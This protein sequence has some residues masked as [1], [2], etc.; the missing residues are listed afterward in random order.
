MAT[1][2]RRSS[3]VLSAATISRH[4]ARPL[5]SR[6]ITA[7]DD[8]DGGEPDGP[9]IV[10]SHELW[11]RRFGGAANVVGAKV[12]VDRSPATI[13]GVAP[14]DFFGPVVGSGFDI[15]VPIKVQPLVQPATPLTAEMTWLTIMCG[16]VPCSVRCGA[17]R[18]VA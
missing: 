4:S 5:L 15:A 14:S 2:P 8:V 3:I 1:P 9:V 11:Q 7:A 12:I 13:V 17:A 6:S 18:P 16:V 10:I